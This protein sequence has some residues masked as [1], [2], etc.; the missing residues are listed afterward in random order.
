MMKMMKEIIAGMTALLSF[1]ATGEMGP[2]RGLSGNC[3]GGLILSSNWG[4]ALQGRFVEKSSLAA[5]CVRSQLGR[6]AHQG[7][8]P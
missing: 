5:S 3:A 8:C 7:F 4:W 1:I 2:P 6:R